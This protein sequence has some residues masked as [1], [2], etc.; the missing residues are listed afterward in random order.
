MIDD[1]IVLSIIVVGVVAIVVIARKKL[2]KPLPPP[3]HFH[4]SHSDV[5][6]TFESARRRSKDG[7]IY[8]CAKCRAF[9]AEPGKAVNYMRK[10][11]ARRVKGLRYLENE[12][13]TYDV[14][15]NCGVPLNPQEKEP[16][17]IQEREEVN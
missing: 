10:K 5:D 1:I 17:K 11:K 8:R 6:F 13:E 14:C 15:P 3:S 9:F 7:V 16:L 2:S 4:S 12:P